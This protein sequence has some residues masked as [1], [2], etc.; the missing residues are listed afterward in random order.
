[1]LKMFRRK[2][3]PSVPAQPQAELDG[4]SGS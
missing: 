4:K 2:A 3:Q 1:M